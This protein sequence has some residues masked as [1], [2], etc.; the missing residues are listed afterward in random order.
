[1]NRLYFWGLVTLIPLIEPISKVGF[2]YHYSNCLIGLAGL[3]AMGWKYLSLQESKQIKK[4]SILL[5]G[6]MSL[7]LILP[8]VNNKVIKKQLF[9][10][11]TVIST[12]NHYD[13]FRNAQLIESDQYS[14][15]ASKI[16]SLSRED[17]TLV[18]S[19]GMQ[20]LY[21]L[22]ELLPPTFELNWLRYLFIQLNFNEDKLI[23]IIKKHR[24]TLIVTTDWYPG[25]AA[26]SA[27]IDKIDLYEKV[28]VVPV[29]PKKN[30]GWKSG[31]IYR[32]KDFE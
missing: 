21:P 26:M 1:M 13:A 12:V 17:S 8:T 19:G 15:L 29:N 32:L 22:T 18:V 10:L 28:E 11:S 14:T 9:S 5:I 7:F 6:L 3:S 24:P 20:V 23:K 4:S 27:I 16:Y 31:T 2:D 25:E 30:Y